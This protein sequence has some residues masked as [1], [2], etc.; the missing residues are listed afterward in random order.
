MN[1]AADKRNP[2]IILGV[3]FGASHSEA[4]AGFARANRS[5]RRNPDAIYSM[6]DL[7]WALHQIEQI[8]EEPEH[9]LHVYRV[10]ANPDVLSPRGRPGLFNPD[11]IPLERRT[12]G[13]TREDIENLRLEELRSRLR[14]RIHKM[15]PPWSTPYETER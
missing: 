10:P 7:T 3:P 11:P 12:A 6:E 2:Y 15:D 9:A 4:R 14:N 13:A 1:P 5:L 8:L